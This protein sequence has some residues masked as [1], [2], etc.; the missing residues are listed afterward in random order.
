MK[1]TICRGIPGTGKSTYAK[2]MNIFHV[3]A[4]MYA[5]H[6]GKYEYDRSKIKHAVEFMK[7]CTETAM[8]QGFDIVVCGTFVSKAHINNIVDIAKKYN[9]EYQI[10]TFTKNYGT[11]HNV[12]IE[13][14]NRMK[15]NWENYEGEVFI[16]D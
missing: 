8:K 10:L 11:I 14:I 9:R 7:N 6:N 4:D 1:L 5:M 16:N 15:N 12:P 3:E 13:T 2:S